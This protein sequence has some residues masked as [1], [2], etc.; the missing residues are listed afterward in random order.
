MTERFE[1]SRRGFLVSML[2]AGGAMVLGTLR[3]A[4]AASVAAEPWTGDV[5]SQAFTQWLRIAPDGI[6]TV[7]VTTPDIGNGVM[8][9]ALAF[10]HEELGGRWDDMRAEYAPTIANYL[11][12][13]YFGKVG[14][15]LGYFSGRSTS[16][17]RRLTYMTAGAG[18]RER[19]RAAAAAAWGV[20]VGEIAVKEGMLSHPSGKAAPFGDMVAAAALIQLDAEPEPKPREE[21]TFL[22]KTAFAKVQIPQI[23]TG[24]AVYGMDV[25]VPGKVYAALR[26]SPVM[27]GTLKSYDFEA[28][29][30][31]PGVRAVVEVKPAE[32]GAAD[33]INSPFPMGVSL[34][35]GGLAVIADHYWQARTALD[36]LPIEWDDGPGA[37]WKTT[38]MMIDAALDAVSKEGE[39]VEYSNGDVAAEFAKG[40]TVIEALY[41]TPYCEQMPMEPLNGVAMV[42]ADKVELWHPSQHTQ[43]AFSVAVQA[44]GVKPENV[45]VHQTFVGGGFGR[46]VFSDDSRVVVEV[47]KGYPGVPVHVMWGREEATR[48]GRYRPLMGAYMK[49]RL[50]DD[51]LP[52]AILARISGGPG[53]YTSSMGDTALPLVVENAQVESTVIK[54]FHVRTGPY[55]GPGY[56]SNIF[57]VESFVDEMAHAA[58]QDPLDYR[59]KLYGRWADKGWIKVLEELKAKSGW[60]EALPPGQGRGVAIGNWGMGGK[61]EKGTTCG[62][63]VHAELSREG[64]LTV[65]RVDVAFD[66]GRIINKDA[67]LVELE[68][69]T[70]FG[71][72]MALNEGLHIKDGRIVE[73]NYD[74]YPLLRMADAPEIHVHF[75]GLTDADRYN[76]IGEPPVGPV[77]PA[78]ANAMF[79]ITGKR[80]RTQPLREH[81]MS[82]S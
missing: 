59:M 67:I 80:L 20:P 8:T 32:S 73:G 58:G 81:D 13:N 79:A 69:G 74:E 1:F 35:D 4:G 41:S 77:G 36:A 12:D 27:R 46:R 16:D 57:F 63:V 68:G 5:S 50:G 72:N 37:K 39:K 62:A 78:L 2:G 11:N 21:W 52:T 6:V 33:L 53:F 19:L 42:S 76:E 30:D 44:S 71:L 29:K 28:I 7:M 9:Q 65:H 51:G 75:G 60:G 66:S 55:R 82:W 49:A 26:L 15:A 48:Q 40:G 45:L 10:V 22:G 14:G 18:A 25:Q 3:P 56:N 38:E 61:A 47:A 24:K 43:M 31:M 17:A 64:V 23:V 34:H 70:L 54:D